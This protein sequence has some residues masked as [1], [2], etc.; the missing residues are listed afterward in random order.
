MTIDQRDVDICIGWDEDLSLRDGAMMP[1][2][3]QTSLFA[4][5]SFQDLI[6][7]LAQEHRRHVY[8]RGHNPTVEAIE[9]KLAAL[10]R[11]DACTCFASG[12]AAISGVMLGLLQAGDHVLFVNQIYGPTLQLANHLIRFGVRHDR[13]LD[14]DPTAI[15]RALTPQTKL[16]WLESPG[17]MLFRVLDVPKIA[18]LAHDR[19]ILTVLDNTWATPLFQ[20]PIA[21][22]VDLVVHTCTKY[23]GGHSDVVAGAVVTSA[24]LLEQIFYRALLL[25]GGVL[26][27]FDAWLLVRGLRTLPERLK[28]H[29]A[30]ALAVAEFLKT[31]EAVHRVY[32]P[33]LAEPRELVE[34]QLTGF[35]GLFSFALVKGEFERVRAVIDRLERFRIGISWGGVESLVTSPNHGKNLDALAAQKIPPGLIRL[36]VGLEDV[37]V[38]IEDLDQA[39][40]AA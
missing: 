28:R 24:S 34:K 27:P 10:E 36:S 32:H 14:R 23:V 16:L 2:I 39:L 13:V 21:M 22:G 15:E 35:S 17:T 30:N 40:S 12:M 3:V 37:D 1:P 4:R 26:G 9:G 18:A 38:L 7:R 8:T 31:H 19:G 11:G 25:N 5:P 29:E 20:K 6:D 33:A